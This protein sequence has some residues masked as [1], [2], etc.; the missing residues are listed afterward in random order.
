MVYPALVTLAALLLYM[1]FQFRVGFS[2]EKY[3]VP[4]PATSGNENWER[5]YRVQMNTLEQLI[6]FL[7]ALWLFA[8]FLSARY[9]AAMGIVFL[10]GRIIYYTGYVRDPSARGTGFG[11]GFLAIVVLILGAAFGV[12]RELI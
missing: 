1:F 9:A 8:Y 7:P 6:I 4:A 11:I 5:L 12:V 2:R 10:I 3:G